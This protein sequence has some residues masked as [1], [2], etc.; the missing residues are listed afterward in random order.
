MDREEKWIVSST[1]ILL[2]CLVVGLWWSAGQESDAYFRATGK[3]IPQWDAV[4]LELR[5]QESVTP[6]TE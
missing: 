5:V 6:H 1:V 4:F 3:R 2:L